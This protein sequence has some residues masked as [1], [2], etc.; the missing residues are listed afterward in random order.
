MDLKAATGTEDFAMM[1]VAVHVAV[2]HVVIAVPVA[3][4]IVTVALL[5]KPPTPPTPLQTVDVTL[6]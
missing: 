6:P 4:V 2:L 3:S 5:A 1:M